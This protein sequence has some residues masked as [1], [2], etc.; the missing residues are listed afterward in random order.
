M[1]EEA[2]V[3][4]IDFIIASAVSEPYQNVIAHKACLTF[5]GCVV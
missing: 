4:N 2:D 1:G 3:A 5:G